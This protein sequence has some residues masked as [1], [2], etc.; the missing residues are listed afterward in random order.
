MGD[1]DPLNGN[2][3]YEK[4]GGDRMDSLAALRSQKK[5]LIKEYRS[6]M[7]TARQD[8]DNEKFKR[9][10]N[11]IEEIEAAWKWLEQNHEPPAADEPISIE[12]RTSDPT[13][14]EPLTV[15]VTGDSG[16][17]ETLVEAGRDG[18]ELGTDQTDGSSGEATFTIGSHG[19]VQFT[20]PTT[21]AYDDATAVVTVDRKTV[22]LAFDG[23]PSEVE[24]DEDVQF[25]VTAA[26]S[27]T[28]DATVETD[29]GT[30]LGTTNGGTVTHAFGST[31]DRTVEATKAD[32]DAATYEPC[33][34]DL[35]VREETVEMELF[36]E[37]SDYEVGETVTVHVNKKNEPQSGRPI[38]GAEVTIAGESDTTGGTGE[39]D[40]ELTAAGELSVEASKSAPNEDRHYPDAEV[41]IDVDRKDGSLRISDIEG[42]RMEGADLTV[43]V[44]DGAGNDLEG[45]SVTTNWG[46]DTET[47]SN[48][49]ATLS[50][51]DDGRLQIEVSKQ[52]DE[53]DYG[54][55][56][57]YVDIEE[58]TR[59]MEIS[60]LQ[61][62][63][64]DPGDTVTVRVTDN[65]GSAVSN[66]TIVSSMQPGT[67]WTTDGSGEADITLSNQV[68][69]R[70]ITARKSD[71]DFTEAG[72]NIRVL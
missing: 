32:D 3:P 51:D 14:D 22:P 12:V 4:I 53:V 34:T 42:K 17:V 25:T 44:V 68:G 47:D 49:E 64:P 28:D 67:E 18:T 52:T 38:E 61:Q 13:V 45:A 41:T 60:V 59:E 30:E 8:D 63:L 46:H 54:S 71:G 16:P 11:A 33:E 39:V 35:K 19:P 48:G 15:A 7:R 9:C 43:H 20:A 40:L 1:A 31:G 55:D 29:G 21:D 57:E 5:D 66:A 36:V 2:D 69:N 72:T 26:G 70:R 56:T 6:R 62:G 10:A 23:A 37:G 58:F 27:P 50:L 24:V 65:T